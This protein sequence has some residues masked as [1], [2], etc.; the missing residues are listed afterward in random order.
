[1][2][3]LSPKNLVQS[4]KSSTSGISLTGP[5]SSLATQLTTPSSFAKLSGMS[6][7]ESP[8]ALNGVPGIRECI[9]PYGAKF[10]RSYNSCSTSIKGMNSDV[11]YN[12]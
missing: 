10:E 5:S 4:T 3:S 11:Q 9:K 6:S 8:E 7:N 12:Q 2:S 1:M